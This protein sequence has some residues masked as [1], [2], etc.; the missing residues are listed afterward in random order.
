MALT[1]AEAAFPPCA[2]T[3]DK[4]SAVHQAANPDTAAL[5]AQIHG[6]KEVAD[7]LRTQLADMREE[8]DRWR[9]QA[10]AVTWWRGRLG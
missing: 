1:L 6:L 2:S 9:D 8:R 7:L 3:Q 10:T 5:E 4:P